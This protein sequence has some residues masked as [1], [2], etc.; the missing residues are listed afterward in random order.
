M[1]CVGVVMVYLPLSPAT[2][3]ASFASVIVVVSSYCKT[4]TGRQQHKKWYPDSI[5]VETMNYQNIQLTRHHLLSDTYCNDNK[6]FN[7]KKWL[8]V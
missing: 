4:C 3:N 6:A 8:H 2:L 7:Y 5:P 1:A